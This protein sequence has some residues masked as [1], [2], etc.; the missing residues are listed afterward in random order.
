[1]K[2]RDKEWFHTLP[3]F[4]Y[5]IDQISQKIKFSNNKIDL[6]LSKIFDR[7]YQGRVEVTKIPH[8]SIFGKNVPK[9]KGV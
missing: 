6:N 4:K 1:M 7:F 3:N 8:I 5:V 9:L 2:E